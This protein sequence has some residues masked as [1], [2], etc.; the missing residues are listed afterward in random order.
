MPATGWFSTGHAQLL[1]CIGMHCAGII[2]AIDVGGRSISHR[3]S[4]T[5]LE[6]TALDPMA[7]L[8]PTADHPLDVRSNSCATSSCPQHI[9]AIDRLR[10]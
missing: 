4:I 5:Q 10:A 7:L 8:A 3:E 2:D 6:A 1:C 9:D